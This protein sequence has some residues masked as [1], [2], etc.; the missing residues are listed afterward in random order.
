MSLIF[1]KLGQK[2]KSLFLSSN[3]PLYANSCL[4]FCSY[5]I[6]NSFEVFFS[7]SLFSLSFLRMS[8]P[9]QSLSIYHFW[10]FLVQPIFLSVQC[11]LCFSFSFCIFP[12]PLSFLFEVQIR[13]P[14]LLDRLPPTLPNKLTTL[15]LPFESSFSCLN[16]WW[17]LSLL[18]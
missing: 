12:L 3:Y 2:K 13:D 15:A 8:L 14:G 10:L 5:F 9:S 6:S 4:S 11:I 17:L 16:I 7:L 1:S 18:A